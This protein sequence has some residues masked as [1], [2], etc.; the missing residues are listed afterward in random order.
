MATVLD[1]PSDR[2][3]GLEAGADDF[4]TKPVDDVA[5]VKRVKSGAVENAHRRD[6]DAR[7]HRS[8]S[9]KFLR[10]INLTRAADPACTLLQLQDVDACDLAKAYSRGR[11]PSPMHRRGAIR[12]GYGKRRRGGDRTCRRH[13]KRA[14]QALYCAKRDGSNRVVADAA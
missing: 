11:A 8:V 9:W 14:D 7:K 1:P 2:V 4:L 10:T 5:L 12:E 13:L 6:A 3:K